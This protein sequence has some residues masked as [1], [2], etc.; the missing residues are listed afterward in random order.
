MRVR[1]AEIEADRSAVLAQLQPYMMPEYSGGI[2]TTNLDLL[3]VARGQC[4]RCCA[5]SGY[6]RPHGGTPHHLLYKCAKCGCEA[7]EHEAMRVDGKEEK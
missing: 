5:C 3:M 4:Q 6:E 7:S 1:S 2:P